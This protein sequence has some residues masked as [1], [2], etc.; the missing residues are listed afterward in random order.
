M[1]TYGFDLDGTLD[2][3]AIAQLANDLYDAGHTILVIT[4]GHADVGEWTMEERINKLGRCE[5]KYTEIVR[6]LA[7]SLEEIGQL[8]TKECVDRGVILMI[9]NDEPYLNYIKQAI[10]CLKIY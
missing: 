4:G 9:D 7:P 5:V 10:T 6:C 1:S 3:P 2:L 8:K